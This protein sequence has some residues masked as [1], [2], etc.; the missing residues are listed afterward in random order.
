MLVLWV[1]IGF[2]LGFGDPIHL[3]GANTGFFAN[4]WGEPGSILSSQDLLGQ[5]HVPELA[6]E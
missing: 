1:L 2:K 6:E 3:F 4:F 5:A